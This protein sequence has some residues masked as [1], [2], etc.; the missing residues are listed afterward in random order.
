VASTEA[1]AC[2]ADQKGLADMAASTEAVACDADH[3]KP[4]DMA[5][6]S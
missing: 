4:A 2:D 3:K 5:A 1:V 6:S